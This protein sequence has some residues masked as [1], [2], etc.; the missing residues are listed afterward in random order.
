MTELQPKVSAV[1]AEIERTA[2]EH[3]AAQT[4]RLQRWRI[5][6]PDA[7]RL[8]WFLVQAL[9][10]WTVVEVGTSRGACALWLAGDLRR[11]GGHLTSWDLDDDAQADA[12]RSLRAAELDDVVDVQLGDGG[13][14]LAA[15]PDASVALLL[16]DSERTQYAS[17]WPPRCVCWPPV[18]CSPSTTPSPTPRRSRRCAPCWRRTSGAPPCRCTRWARGSSLPHGGTDRGQVGR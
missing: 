16:L 10:A 6:E 17:W 11:T 14:A 15:L 2:V 18:G 3:D 1:I 5:I 8:L 13:A 12:R 7:G 4:D 9:G